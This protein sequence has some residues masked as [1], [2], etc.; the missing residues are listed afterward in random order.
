MCLVSFQ[1]FDESTRVVKRFEIQAHPVNN[2]VWM[3]DRSGSF[4][5]SNEGVGVVQYWNVASNEPRQI[6][7]IGSKGTNAMILMDSRP[8]VGARILFAL[9]NGALAVYNLKK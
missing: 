3:L 2:I 9:N 7:K 8:T 4:V 5:T 6:N 1:G